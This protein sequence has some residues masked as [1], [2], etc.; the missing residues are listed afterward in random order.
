MPWLNL[1]L[2]GCW[3][4]EAGVFFLWMLLGCECVNEIEPIS[5]S[6]SLRQA[7]TSYHI[8]SDASPSITFLIFHRIAMHSLCVSKEPVT[9][10]GRFRRP[11][12]H[13]FAPLCPNTPS[14]SRG[15]C[16]APAWKPPAARGSS[17]RCGRGR[18]VAAKSRSV[19]FATLLIGAEAVD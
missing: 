18:G 3:R 8:L 1:F 19:V 16:R 10:A 6:L 14:L 15:W 17:S 9:V 2:R 5:L 13:R 7:K 11:W 4:P 12:N